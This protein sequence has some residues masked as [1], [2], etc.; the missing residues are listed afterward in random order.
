M[1]PELFFTMPSHVLG[2]HVLDR[3]SVGASAVNFAL[4]IGLL[5]SVWWGIFHDLWNS[6]KNA[7]KKVF[8]VA[9]RTCASLQRC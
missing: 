6:I 4:H 7:A 9:G 8:Q 1:V 2:N 5:W 3:G